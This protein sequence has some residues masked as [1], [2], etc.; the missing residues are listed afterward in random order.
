MVVTAN[1]DSK[2]FVEALRQAGAIRVITKPWDPEKVIR[3]V[4]EALERYTIAAES[5]QAISLLHRTNEE[6]NRF[7]RR[8]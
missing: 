3:T 6:L 5:R 7:V 2:T 4:C 8:R 1:R